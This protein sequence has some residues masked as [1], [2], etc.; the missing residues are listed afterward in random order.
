MQQCDKRVK[1]K[2]QKVLGANSYVWK[3]LQGKTD[4]GKSTKSPHSEQVQSSDN[5]KFHFS[6]LKNLLT[7]E[8]SIN[9][10]ITKV[11]VNQTAPFLS[12]S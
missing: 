2:I 8:H 6:L 10:N 7:S 11:A 4:R 12:L 1:T 9:C 3:K 5:I